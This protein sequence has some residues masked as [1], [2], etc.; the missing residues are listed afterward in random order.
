M[1]EATTLTSMAFMQGLRHREFFQMRAKGIRRVSG[2]LS[3]LLLH[4]F[5]T[6][7]ARAEQAPIM[8]Q[9]CN[10]AFYL[11]DSMQKVEETATSILARDSRGTELAVFCAF[12]ENRTY[13]PEVILGRPGVKEIKKLFLEHEIQGILYSNA[14][15]SGSKKLESIEAYLATRNLEYR[16]IVI[17]ADGRMDGQRERSVNLAEDILARF[18]WIAPPEKTISEEQYEQ[19]FYMLLALVLVL[20]AAIL[21]FF[22]RRK[23][24]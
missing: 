10:I 13:R 22:L 5:L 8:L 6:G 21:V 1:T 2:P 15:Y 16:I 18:S 20:A 9:K 19:R 7:S 12:N 14:R 23:K 24:G 11:P 17:P 4:I 3:V